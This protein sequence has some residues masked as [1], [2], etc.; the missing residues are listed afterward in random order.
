MDQATIGRLSLWTIR[1]GR[2]LFIT[3]LALIFAT[4]SAQ[5]RTPDALTWLTGSYWRSCSGK[6][7]CHLSRSASL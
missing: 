4:A 6:V 3:L 5:D 2:R 1:R 7:I